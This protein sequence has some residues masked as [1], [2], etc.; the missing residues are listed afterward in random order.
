MG[1]QSRRRVTM[2]KGK[3]AM[4]TTIIMVTRKESASSTI[5]GNVL[6][7]SDVSLNISVGF[8]ANM[9]M[10][11]IIAEKSNRYQITVQN[12]TGKLGRGGE[13]QIMMKEIKNKFWQVSLNV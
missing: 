7:V 6:L 12:M 4:V 9:D 11:L 8:V 3:A 2:E 10:E 1:V 5:K 13:D